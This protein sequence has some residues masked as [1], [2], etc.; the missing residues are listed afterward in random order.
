MK[1]GFNCSTFDL[2]KYN[3]TGDKNVWLYLHDY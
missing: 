1:I 2:Y 3:Q